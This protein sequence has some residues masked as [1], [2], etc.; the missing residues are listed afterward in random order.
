MMRRVRTFRRVG[1]T[2]PQTSWDRG[3]FT[4]SS[5]TNASIVA[6][7]IFDPA[8]FEAAAVDTEFTL[9]RQHHSI[10]FFI[11]PGTLSLATSDVY[12]VI[13]GI[14]KAGRAE[15][16]RD[17]GMSAATDIQA[18]WLWLHRMQKRVSDVQPDTF[19]GVQV[20]YNLDIKAKRKFDQNENLVFVFKSQVL[21][22]NIT[23]F[24][25][26]Q[27]RASVSNLYQETQRRR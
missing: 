1:G 10:Q 24:G 22:G 8:L 16:T 3:V 12:E 23:V 13:M 19:E 21:T 11:D 14:Y 25:Q 15:P 6:Q 17:P 20:P 9:L 2:R 26:V 4:L 27:A 7:V 18:D 5:T